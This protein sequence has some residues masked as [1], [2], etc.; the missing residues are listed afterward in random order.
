MLMRRMK[1]KRSPSDADRS[2]DLQQTREYPAEKRRILA[3]LL[4]SCSGFEC[5]L[6]PTGAGAALR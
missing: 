4:D 2:A 6:S 3:G 1:S 5:L